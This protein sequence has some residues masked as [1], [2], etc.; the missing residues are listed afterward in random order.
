MAASG[1]SLDPRGVRIRQ[2]ATAVR[3]VFEDFELKVSQEAAA[4][5]LQ[6]GPV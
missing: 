5:L 6:D 4:V 2:L 1:D 3:D